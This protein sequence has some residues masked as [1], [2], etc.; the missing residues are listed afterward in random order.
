MGAFVAMAIII[1]RLKLFGTPH[2]CIIASI[3]ANFEVKKFLN[4]FFFRNFEKFFLVV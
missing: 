4:L 1:M 2:L 3:L